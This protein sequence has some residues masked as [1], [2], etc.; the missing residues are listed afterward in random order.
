MHFLLVLIFFCAY[1]SFSILPFAHIGGIF[2]IS[3][4]GLALI[5]L[6]L[7]YCIILSQQGKYDLSRLIN[8][9]TWFIFAYILFVIMQ[10][11]FAAMIYKQSVLSGLIIAR[12]QF[13]YGSF[14]LFLMLIDNRE[15]ADRF[16]RF[17]TV[18]SIILICLSLVNYFGPSIGYHK[19]VNDPSLR[20]GIRRAIVP[21][22][23]IILFAGLWHLVRYLNDK[24]ATIWSLLF[25]L[26]AYSA[27]IF[28]QTRGRVVALTIT[29]FLMLFIRKKYKLLVGLTFV[30]ISFSALFNITIGQNILYNQFGSAYK[31]YTEKSGNWGARVEQAEF[32][33][34]IIK[35]HPLTGSGGLVIRDAPGERPTEEMRWLAAGADLGYMNWIKYFGLPGILWMMF[36]IA[37]FF[38]KLRAILQNPLT[39]RVMVNFAGYMFIYI[40][41]AE[42]TLDSFYRP[43][44]ILLLCVTLAMLLNSGGV[45]NR[46]NNS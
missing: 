32:A 12:H 42:V 23:S 25:F 27:V 3:D 28:R 33:W 20:F 36:F 40:L 24:K 43:T 1:K 46:R 19:N 5:W 21:G 29:V 39:D 2:N 31:E 45:L 15:S 17:L 18:L 7:L 44:G 35:Q 34:K 26:L 22:V 41:I 37:I 14:F 10:A 11:S 13:Y 9:F 6:G 38:K 8:T 16:M 30:V 4:V